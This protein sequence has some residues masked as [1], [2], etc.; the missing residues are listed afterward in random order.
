MA[1]LYEWVVYPNGKIQQLGFYMPK[2]VAS[3]YSVYYK[4]ERFGA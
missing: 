2:A 4:L 3:A 1:V